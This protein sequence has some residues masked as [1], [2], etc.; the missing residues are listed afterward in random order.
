MVVTTTWN[1]AAPLPALSITLRTT[2]IWSPLR[3]KRTEKAA[4]VLLIY[5]LALIIVNGL[6][7]DIK[8]ILGID[9]SSPPGRFEIINYQDNV[10]IIDYA[11]TPDEMENILKGCNELKNGNIITVIG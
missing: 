7:Y 3:K 11:H 6:G 10:I 9:V 2:V 5:L 1:R 8:E 4:P